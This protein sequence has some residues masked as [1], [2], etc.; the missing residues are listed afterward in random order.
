MEMSLKVA[1]YYD[2]ITWDRMTAQ[3]SWCHTWNITAPSKGWFF[4]FFVKSEK[5]KKNNI[6]STCVVALSLMLHRI[7]LSMYPS[8]NFLIGHGA[9]REY[10]TPLRRQVTIPGVR[11][12][13]KNIRTG[14]FKLYQYWTVHHAVP[15]PHDPA[16][17]L[18]FSNFSSKWYIDVYFKKL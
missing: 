12:E 14:I 1:C 18:W 17:T 9:Q 11:R 4:F 13:Q 10:W 6:V 2:T 7:I 3:R 15:A 8:T 16:F 5:E